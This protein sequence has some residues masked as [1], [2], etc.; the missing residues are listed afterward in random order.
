MAVQTLQGKIFTKSQV[1][2]DTYAFRF[3]CDEMP[4]FDFQPG[5]F[6]TLTVAPNVRRS[7]SIASV[8]GKEYIELIADTKRAGPGSM[9]FLNSQ[10]G[11]V[12]EFMFPLGVFVYKENPKPVYFFG[13]GTGIV[14]FMSMA[15]YALAIQKTQR[16]VTMYC[17]FRYEEDVFG[18]EFLELLDIQYQN[19]WFK[20]N[21]TQ[22]TPEWQGPTGRIT[23]YIDIL[24]KTDVEAYICGSN[25]VVSDIKEKLIAKGVPAAQIYHEMFY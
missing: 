13:T 24:P 23:Q 10:V 3:T 5:Q 25:E 12:F 8:P 18:K 14:P 9:F 11:D 19:F 16:E 2:K 20:L 7:Y 21:V 1:A 15:E 17:S 6:V 4:S 22:P